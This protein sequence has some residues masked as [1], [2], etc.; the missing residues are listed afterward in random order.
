MEFKDR[1]KALR[2]E[3]GVSQEELGKFLKYEHATISQYE[4][5]KRK[6]DFE[7][8]QKLADYFNTTTDYLLGRTDIRNESASIE[9]VRSAVSDDPELL[10]C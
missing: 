4:S 5:G 7:T 8:L 1:L 10:Q 6:P 2:T 3:K 9:K